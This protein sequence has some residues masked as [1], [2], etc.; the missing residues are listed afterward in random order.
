[1]NN[2][3]FPKQPSSA[4][5]HTLSKLMFLVPDGFVPP[6]FEAVYCFICGSRRVAVTRYRMVCLVLV[7]WLSLAS[8]SFQ[9]YWLKLA[10]I[11]AW[12]PNSLHSRKAFKQLCGN[13][14]INYF[15]MTL[16]SNPKMYSCLSYFILHPFIFT[17]I[18]K[19]SDWNL[20]TVHVSYY[21]G[22]ERQSD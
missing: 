8:L 3:Y 15:T 20:F 5:L 13:F 1:M 11:P 7:N 9:V 21:K 2:Y 16:T 18:M 4:P 14:L 22:V 6:Y 10:I 19:F 17:C 12:I